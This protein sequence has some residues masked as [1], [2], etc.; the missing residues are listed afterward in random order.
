MK[1]APR[2][3]NMTDLGRI[4]SYSVLSRCHDS[5]QAV[6]Q[7]TRPIIGR[8]VDSQCAAAFRAILRSPV[9]GFSWAQARGSYSPEFSGG[10]TPPA[11]TAGSH[12]PAC[13]RRTLR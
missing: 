8:G 2:V 7:G 1:I 6:G 9:P 10:G 13:R 11:V 3:R 4:P 12:A 5:A